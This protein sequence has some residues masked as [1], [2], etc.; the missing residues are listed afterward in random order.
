MTTWGSTEAGDPVFDNSWLDNLQD[1][2]LIITKALSPQLVIK[3]LDNKDKCILHLTVTG[4]GGSFME[5]NVPKCNINADALTELIELGFPEKQIVL[6]I[7]PMIS[8]ELGKAVLDEFSNVGVTRCRFSFLNLTNYTDNN[9]AKEHIQKLHDEAE[10]LLNYS[11]EK[12]YNYKFESCA[13][14]W[15]K[16]LDVK[17]VGCMSI[18]EAEAVLGYKPEFVFGK[19]NRDFCLAP[20]NRVELLNNVPCA[21]NCRYCFHS[22]AKK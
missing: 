2:N 17:L 4:L 15:L 21:H 1:I 18:K 8:V 6:R 14:P 10:E 5:P 11:K 12:G 13:G 3:L 7:D 20:V 19:R 9:L 22:Q 16:D